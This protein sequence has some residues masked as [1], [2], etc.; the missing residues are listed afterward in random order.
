MT[1]CCGECAHWE[2]NDDSR[3]GQCH[4]PTPESVTECAW[5]DMAE[6]AGTACPCFTR[7]EA[8]DE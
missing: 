7:K 6:N 5:Y 4:A 1:Q 8:N 3:N 2:R